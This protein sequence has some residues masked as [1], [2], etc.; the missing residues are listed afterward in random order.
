MDRLVQINMKYLPINQTIMNRDSRYSFFHFTMNNRKFSLV[1]YYAI[2]IC[3]NESIF[4]CLFSKYFND[5]VTI[6]WLD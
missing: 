5:D 3:Y 4:I 2:G 6:N 1:K